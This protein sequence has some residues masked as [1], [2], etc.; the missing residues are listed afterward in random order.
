[1][2]TLDRK[3]LFAGG[4]FDPNGQIFFVNQQGD[5]GNLPAGGPP[6]GEE[7]TYAIWGPWK[8]IS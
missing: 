8:S 4:T 2:E 5:R 1:M 7:V 6:D 3:A